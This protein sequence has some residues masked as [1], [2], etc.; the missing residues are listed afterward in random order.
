M[1]TRSWREIRRQSKLTPEQ[2]VD[3]EREVATEVV[4][5]KAADAEMT[6][7]VDFN[8]HGEAPNES[9]AAAFVDEAM[10]A[11]I[12]VAEKHGCLIGGG[13]GARPSAQP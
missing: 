4:R 7:E 5:L 1:P 13:L 2:R 3:V 10:D 6:W 11:L 9:A 12:A 8:L